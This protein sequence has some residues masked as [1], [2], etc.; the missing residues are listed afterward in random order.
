MAFEPMRSNTAARGEG[1]SA[2]GDL[3]NGAGAGTA[4]C[5]AHVATGDAGTAP[6]FLATAAVVGRGDT[7]TSGSDGEGGTG[8]PRA[9]AKVPAAD[10][11]C[12]SPPSIPNGVVSELPMAGEIG[13]GDDWLSIPPGLDAEG[14]KA[15]KAAASAMGSN[16]AGSATGSC[17][18]GKTA[19]GGGGGGGGGGRS[20]LTLAVV[21]VAPCSPAC[22]ICAAARRARPLQPEAGGGGGGGGPFTGGDRPPSRLLNPQGK[23]PPG[24]SGACWCWCWNMAADTG[25]PLAAGRVT[26]GCPLPPPNACGGGCPPPPAGPV[27]GAKMLMPG[28]PSILDKPDNSAMPV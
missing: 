5:D 27:A 15:A 26:Q 6:D 20:A 14:K 22:S 24:A 4:S 11:A 2:G 18:C 12:D 21:V 23:L 19:R 10:V 8:K 16:A 7:C 17:T 3:A 1:A 9:A 28:K 13:S 25:E